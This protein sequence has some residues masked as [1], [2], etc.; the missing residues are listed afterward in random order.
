MIGLY[1]ACNDR[2]LPFLPGWL[3]ARKQFNDSAPAH[4]IA[5]DDNISR[6]KE[7]CAENSV[8]LLCDAAQDWRRIGQRI[9]GES[10]Y[11]RDVLQADYFSKLAAFT[12]PLR[13]FVFSDVNSL[14]L[15]DVNR[16]FGDMEPDGCRFMHKARRFR[17][18]RDSDVLRL[19]RKLNP[20]FGTG[21]NAS[22]FL[23]Q[24]NFI[25]LAEAHE[26][27]RHEAYSAENFG[28]A[29]EQSLLAWLEVALH[30]PCGLIREIFPE[31]SPAKR[32]S[33]LTIRDNHVYDS[34]GKNVHFIKWNGAGFGPGIRHWNVAL[35]FRRLFETEQEAAADVQSKA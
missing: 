30:K 14:V 32:R 31:L 7:F 6:L 10:H 26:A 33:L 15:F 24:G 5:F 25:T 3:G 8:S 11:R 12:G 21:Y 35:H 1:T 18:A 13:R 4:V 19:Y 9:Y 34:R 2:M 27:L 17:I 22:F 29:P 16:R 28:R 23:S 20:S